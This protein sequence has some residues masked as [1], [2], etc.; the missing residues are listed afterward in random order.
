MVFAIYTA[1]VLVLIVSLLL[2][3][4]VHAAEVS[5]VVIGTAVFNRIM[6][7]FGSAG[8]DPGTDIAFYGA[9]RGLTEVTAWRFAEVIGWVL[10]AW[11]VRRLSRQ[12]HPALIP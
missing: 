5:A 11:V 3:M 8:G 12:S 2:R 4:N 7:S 1:P 6:F 9:Y 10:V